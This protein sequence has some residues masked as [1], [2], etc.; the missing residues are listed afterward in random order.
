MKNLPSAP[1]WE[2]PLL[3]PHGLGDLNKFGRRTA[4]R[5]LI[6]AIDGVSVHELVEAYGSPV[7]VTSERRLRENIRKIRRAF[8][9]RWP[10]VVHGWSYKTNYTTAICNILHQEGSIAEVVSGFEYDK[11]RHNGVAGHDIIFNG[12]NKKRVQLERAIDEGAMIHVDH[13]DELALIGDIASERRQ[14]VRLALRLTF[15]TGFTEAW[16]RFGFH[17]ESG[18][19]HEAARRIA[20]HPYLQLHGLHSHIGTF[21]LDPRAYESQVKIMCGFMREVEAGQDHLID[22]IDIGGGL[23]SRNALQG[24]YQ[25]PQQAVPDLDDYAEAICGALARE[26][27]YRLDAGQK[28]PR[29]IFESGRAVVDDA[30]SLIASVCGLKMLP[31]GRRSAILDAGVN[32]L[33]SARN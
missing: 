17:L 25:P 11:A 9:S 4:R 21:I 28:R 2:T 20:A 32:V 29:L 14:N 3:K 24:V 5:D 31:D 26:T 7:F 15:D 18:Q 23:P 1:Q 27:Q 16:S 12:P 6:E 19:A 33:I 22:Y 13:F 30:Q 10:D 8:D